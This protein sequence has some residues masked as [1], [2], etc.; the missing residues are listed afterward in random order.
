MGEVNLELALLFTTNNANQEWLC[1]RLKHGVI[2]KALEL[3]GGILS[4]VLEEDLLATCGEISACY[5]EIQRL[6]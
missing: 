5:K 1:N 3:L 4:G 2:V 6:W